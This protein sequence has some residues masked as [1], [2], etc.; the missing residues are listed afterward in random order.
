MDIW[1]VIRGYNFSPGAWLLGYLNV[2][3]VTVVEYKGLKRTTPG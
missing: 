3:L 2:I 1:N